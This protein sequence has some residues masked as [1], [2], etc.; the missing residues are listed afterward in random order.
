MPS[1]FVRIAAA[2]SPEKT[3]EMIFPACQIPIRRGDS[4]FVYQDDVRRETAG[5]KGPS[6]TPTRNRQRQNPQPVVS[7]GIQIV[8]ADHPSIIEGIRTLGLPLAM[9][10]LAGTWERM[11][12]T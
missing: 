2:R 8:T 12:P 7:A 1:M 11:Y 9:I 6:V 4:L 3:L 5:T 10:T